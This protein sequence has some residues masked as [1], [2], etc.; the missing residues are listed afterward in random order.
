M[1]NEDVIKND[2]FD[3]SVLDL[4]NEAVFSSPK[5][6]NG[7]EREEEQRALINILEDLYEDK[8]KLEQQRMA[9]F[10]ILEDV[11]KTQVSLQR[12]YKELDALKKLTE[13]LGSSLKADS[14]MDTLVQVLKGL[15]P[16]TIISYVV[17]SDNEIKVYSNY[18]LG[19]KFLEGLKDVFKKYFIDHKNKFANL[20]LAKETG[21]DFVFDF[22]E[23][24][25]KSAHNQKM[26]SEFSFDFIIPG[27][28]GAVINI[29]TLEK[30]KVYDEEEVAMVDIVASS[31]VQTIS[32]LRNLIDSERS[33]VGDLV[34]SMSNGVLMF[35]DEKRIVIANNIIRD[36]FDLSSK[37]I[38]LSDFVQL[39]KK[40]YEESHKSKKG[41]RE[42]VE[43][44]TLV[45]KVLQEEKKFH[46]E[47]FAFQKKFFEIFIIPVHGYG[48]KVSGGSFIFHDITHLKE[49]DKMKTEF[50]SVASHQLRTP[51]TSMNW[52]MEM[53][54]A[55][56]AGEMNNAQLEYINEV[57]RGS[58]R[59][60]KLVNELLNVSRLETGRLKIAPEPVD[61]VQFI[62]EIIAEAEKLPKAA[63]VDII[64]EK[65][66]K[67]EKVM[68]DPSLFRQ[69]VHNFVTNAIRYSPVDKRTSVEVKLEVAGDSYQISV[70]DHGIGIPKEAQKR[71][72]EK[73][74]RAD[75][76]VGASA[77][78]SGLG[79]YIAKMVMDAVGGKIWFESEEG[80]GTTFFASFPVSGMKSKAGEKGLA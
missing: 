59:M 68:V 9:I 77:E 39:L 3:D 49:I 50:V 19:E 2:N 80:K 37:V 27:F 8:E 60:V 55:G 4:Q 12:R 65:P 18:I 66:D 75:N 43:F 36:V 22:V 42:Q 14:I 1:N 21:D 72:F 11:N 56:D 62:Q 52:Y 53:L 73:F 5:T 40:S 63:N 47:E 78:G 64:F 74:F 31:A 76:A 69:V 20:T 45:D 71:I 10:N 29:S 41:E 54:L 46:I 67:I 7:K 38:N 23:M 15:F 6:E 24:Q 57:Y 58:K 13:Q 28:I 51:L 35:D 44:D 61:L 30:K 17:A 16:G 79:L 70:R 26:G 34:E 32:R 48:N 25:E 33:K